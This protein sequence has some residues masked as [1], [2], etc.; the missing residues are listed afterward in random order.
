VAWNTGITWKLLGLVLGTTALAAPF[1]GPAPRPA[2]S[3]PVFDPIAPNDVFD[4][5]L[6]PPP[7]CDG[8]RVEVQAV[9]QSTARRL[10][11]QRIVYDSATL[12]DCSGMVHRVLEKVE[13]RCDDVARPELT[14]ARSARAIAAWYA[15]QGKLTTV[16]DSIDADEALA[17]GAIA[18]FGAPGKVDVPLERIFHIGVVY[19]VQRNERGEVESYRMFH[20]R[21]PGKVASITRWHRRDADP[22]LGNG[23]EQ[24]VA[25]AWPS[26]DLAPL[27][28]DQLVADAFADRPIP[29]IK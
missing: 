29:E 24:L 4:V 7:A 22:P 25:V 11:A 26:P 2:L 19:D 17:P 15:Q 21:R 9:V 20:G 3:T 1:R 16:L 5:P 18:F 6:P 8:G 23:N 13:Q 14:V 10:A 12:A 27:G 28:A